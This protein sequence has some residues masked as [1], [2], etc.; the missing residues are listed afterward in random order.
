M[1]TGSSAST[2]PAF[3]RPRSSEPH[4]HWNTATTTPK[5]AAEASRFITAAVSGTRTLRKA[6]I[7]S[8]QPSTTITARKIG[9]LP[10]SRSARS[11]EVAVVP[12]T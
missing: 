7:S 2:G 5:D 12:P 3:P 11:P 4:P 10:A 9:S 6:S 1:I 8:R